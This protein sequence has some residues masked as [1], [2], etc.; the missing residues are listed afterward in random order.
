MED[1]QVYLFEKDGSYK[2][3]YLD[4]GR[5][6]VEQYN[7]DGINNP[8]WEQRDEYIQYREPVKDWLEV[9]TLTKIVSIDSYALQQGLVEGASLIKDNLNYG[10]CTGN[11]EQPMNFGRDFRLELHYAVVKDSPLYTI[12]TELEKSSSSKSSNDKEVEHQKEINTLVKKIKELER[13]NKFL[14]SE[15]SSAKES[16][17]DYKWKIIELKVE[18]EWVEGTIS[19]PSLALLYLVFINWIKSLFKINK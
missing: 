4:K 7:Q 15:V 17:S 13:N 19:K 18:N 12:I 6:R 14:T 10:Q 1:K 16:L 5:D 3:I 11:Q 8:C 2:I 9:K